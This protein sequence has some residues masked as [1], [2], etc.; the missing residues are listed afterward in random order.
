MNEA[1]ADKWFPLYVAT[2]LKWTMRLTTEEHGAYL[3][4]IMACWTDGG[5]LPNDDRQLA[6]ITKMTLPAWRRA[7][8]VI[9][10]FFTVDGGLLTHDRVTRE[11]TRAEAVSKA[12]S[13][14]GKQGGRP[15]KDGSKPKAKDKPN[16]KKTETHAG[17]ALQITT[18]LVA[19]TGQTSSVRDAPVLPCEGQPA[20]APVVFI[21]DLPKAER[22]ALAA[23]ATVGL[24][25]RRTH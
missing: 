22:V 24:G 18:E 13:E 16:A 23:S 15:P 17:V 7:K 6:S 9:L 19:P 5:S 25:V 1:K 21:K 12:R 2:Y 4:L 11:I 8:A 14:A 20:S 10:P 3:L